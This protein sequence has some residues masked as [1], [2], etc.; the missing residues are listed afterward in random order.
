MR[1]LESTSSFKLRLLRPSVEIV[2]VVDG[3]VA[4]RPGNRPNQGIR[5]ILT[6][7]D[8]LFLRRAPEIPLHRL[9][10]DCCDGRATTGRL[11]AELLVRALG[12]A[13]IGGDEPG[14]GRYRDIAISRH[15]RLRSSP[16]WRSRFSKNG[17]IPF[18]LASLDCRENRR[19]LAFR[20]AQRVTSRAKT[21]R[22]ADSR[23]RRSSYRPSVR[24]PEPSGGRGWNGCPAC[25]AYTGCRGSWGSMPGVP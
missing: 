13:K 9:T 2:I 10:Y 3:L 1:A 5:R 18:R 24:G 21:S 8:R 12:E 20:S 11:Q 4:C 22:L 7:G 15:R 23:Q 17:P 19:H 14:H 25:P 16:R 6:E